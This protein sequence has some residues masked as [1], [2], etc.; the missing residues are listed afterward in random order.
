MNNVFIMVAL[1]ILG[2]SF[3]SFASATV[4]R[5]HKKKDIVNDRSECESCHH[6]LAWYD[7]IPV[8]SWVLLSGKCRYC[9]KPIRAELPLTELLTAVLFVGSYVMWPYSMNTFGEGMLFGLWLVAIILLVILFVYDMKWML[10]PDKVVFP[11]I[12]VGTLMAITRFTIAE[13]MTATIL[14]SVYAVLILSGLYL[15]LFVV[16]KGKWVGLGDVK[17]G[18]FLG[19]G[20]GSWELALLC[21][22]LANFLGCLVVVPGILSGKMKRT[23]RVPFGPFLIGGFL[24][25]FIFGQYIIDWYLMF[26]GF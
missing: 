13:D 7:L 3:G 11:L 15:A 10:L 17:L 4:W 12:A 6:K 23:S 26:S 24:L 2:L 1:A 14:G 21:L 16:S 25:T 5:L 20:L 8:I 19:L 18:I 9:K 22:F